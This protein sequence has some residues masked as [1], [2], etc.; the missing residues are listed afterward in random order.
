MNAK[1]VLKH[2]DVRM[3]FTFNYEEK[4]KGFFTHAKTDENVH[5]VFQPLSF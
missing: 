5:C 3:L 1:N 2:M 4:R